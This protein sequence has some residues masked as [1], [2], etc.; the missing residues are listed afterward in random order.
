MG[1]NSS[2]A[3]QVMAKTTPH[4][5][6]YIFTFIDD[7]QRTTVHIKCP[8]IGPPPGMVIRHVVQPSLLDWMYVE[9][10]YQP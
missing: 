8:A 5:P 10:K 9:D 6:D 2:T 3:A 1:V 7:Q 4:K